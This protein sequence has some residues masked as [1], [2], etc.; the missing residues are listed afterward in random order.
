M[1]TSIMIHLNAM[2][3]KEKFVRKITVGTF[4]Y[5]AVAGISPSYSIDQDLRQQIHQ[6]WSKQ[7][8]QK[9]EQILEKAENQEIQSLLEDK[10]REGIAKD[11][12]A[13]KI[14]QALQKRQ[15]IH[16]KISKSENSTL[17]IRERVHQT[18]IKLSGEKLDEINANNMHKIEERL[19]Q[20]AEKRKNKRMENREATPSLELNPDE[21]FITKENKEE[22]HPYIDEKESRKPEKERVPKNFDQTEK[23]LEQRQERQEM[24]G[25][26]REFEDKIEER[27]HRNQEKLIEKEEK[28][29][30]KIEEEKSKLEERRIEEKQKQIEDRQ[31]SED[32]I[33]KFDREKDKRKNFQP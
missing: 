27:I 28:R 24:K 5:L 14:L 13:E 32:K 22:R 21:A 29:R 26:K 25:R 19:R 31:D 6:N 16:E 12:S 33:E 9:L 2:N 10:L 8:S 7:Q 1:Y 15:E 17:R 20:E 23:F 3:R 30:E 4:F 18:E 11:A